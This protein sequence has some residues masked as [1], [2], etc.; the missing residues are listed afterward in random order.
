MAALTMAPATRRPEWSSNGDTDGDELVREPYYDD[1]SLLDAA[2]RRHVDGRLVIAIGQLEGKL[3]EAIKLAAGG[4][5]GIA[6]EWTPAGASTALNGYM[7]LAEIMDV[8]IDRRRD[9]STSRPTV[10][11]AHLQPFLYGTEITA[12]SATTTNPVGTLTVGSVAGDVAAEARLVIT[13]GS[14]EARRWVEW[15][16]ESFYFNASAPAPLFLDSASLVTSGFAGA[17]T[18]ISGAFGGSAIAASLLSQP[19]AVCSTGAQP[20]IGTY[21]VKGRVWTASTAEYWRLTWQEADGPFSRTLGR[22]PVAGSAFSELDFGLVTIEPV[23][24]GAQTWTGRF[25]AYTTTAAA[26]SA[27]LITSTCSRSTKATVGSRMR[28]PIRPV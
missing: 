16:L 1:R 6:F 25:E 19:T 21:R 12:G 10:N 14:S 24:A 13:D 22:Q 2:P 18:A 3:Q 4:G 11:V 28:T 23:E 5:Q 27:R 7:T 20:H 26:R 8:P 15:G 9:G 17:G